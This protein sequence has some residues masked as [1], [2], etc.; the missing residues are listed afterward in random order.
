MTNYEKLGSFPLEPPG[1]VPAEL[2]T[3]IN[4]VDQLAVA[5]ENFSGKIHRYAKMP[6]SITQTHLEKSATRLMK[7]LQN[8]LTVVAESADESSNKAELISGIVIQDY[9]FRKNCA[10]NLFGLEIP[11]EAEEERDEFVEMV[12]ELAEDYAG[13][14]KDLVTHLME[15]ISEDFDDDLNEIVYRAESTRKG[16]MVLVGKII[17]RHTLRLTEAAGG[18]VVGTWFYHHYLSG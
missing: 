7:T 2:E 3:I 10:N 12:T 15:D 5:Q 17:G 16:R 18:A 4:V 6:C 11:E 14:P 13:R 1:L 9:R 8:S